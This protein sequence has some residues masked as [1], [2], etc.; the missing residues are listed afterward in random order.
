MGSGAS[1][2][3]STQQTP[4][5]QGTPRRPQ[6]TTNRGGHFQE[7]ELQAP[8]QG[9]TINMSSRSQQSTP[10]STPSNQQ[11]RYARHSTNP[12]GS[13]YHGQSTAATSRENRRTNEEKEEDV[14]FETFLHQNGREFICAVRAG[15][16]YYLD[17]WHSHD[18]QFFPERWYSEGTLVPLNTG[19][20]HGQNRVPSARNADDNDDR[21]GHLKHPK[22]GKVQTYLM[23]ERHYVHFFFDKYS[24]KWL[25]LPIGWEL[26]HELVKQMVDHVEEALPKWRDRADIL[27][28]LRA[29]N[30]NPDECIGTYLVLEEDDW[31]LP[32]RTSKDA[33]ADEM[34]DEKI[35]E[36]TEKLH[37]LE[38]ELLAEKKARVEAEQQLSE[39][40]EKYSKISADATSAQRQVEAMQQSRPKTARPKTPQVAIVP[41]VSE[42]DLEELN[43]QVKNLHKTH[44]R[45]KMDMLRNIGSINA[46]ISDAIKAASDLKKSDVG[47][48]QEL[49]EIRSLYQREALQRRLLYNQLQE[50][51][52]NIRVFCR[53]RRDDRARNCLGFPSD[54]DITVTNQDGGK[55]TFSFDKVYTSDSTQEN[56]FVD[57]QPIITSCV[58]GYNVCLL[59]YGQTGSG[60]TFTMMGPDNNP[61]INIRAISE[62][63]KVCSERSETKSFTL[64]VSMVEIYNETVQDLLTEDT[65]VLELSMVGNSVKIPNIMEMPVKEV[66]DIKEIMKLGDSNRKTASTKMNSTSSRSHLVLMIT[67][68]GEDKVTGAISKGVLTLC[69][70]AGSERISKTEATGQRLV[71]AAAINKS[72]SALGQVFLALRES[73][74]HIPYRNSKLTQILRPC[75]GGDAKACLFVNISPDVSNSQETCNTLEF[76]SN[77]RQVALGQAKQNIQKKG[78][79]FPPR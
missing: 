46:V 51:R 17:D 6:A 36:L 48:K 20:S 14:Q 12:N 58:D 71:E 18:W 49:E 56:I 44:V 34:K 4:R 66:K 22:R 72:L 13:L 73:Q 57:T 37:K 41:L 40:V 79:G 32:Q 39:L 63:L 60:K 25:R 61:G 30:Y 76:G 77:A 31:L 47:S 64:K 68:E 70:L 10:R 50:L 24:G 8:G 11:T 9:R 52:G 38:S 26:H 65:K 67:V 15:K 78:G 27:A 75:L 5:T 16:R 23:E 28:L 19:E 59:A 3:N 29:C 54:Q 7:V 69:D 55:K 21:V 74:L 1:K 45:L 43:Q 53:P 35:Q 42:R 33:K 2:N 62:L